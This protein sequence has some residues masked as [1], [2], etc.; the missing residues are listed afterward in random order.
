M[1]PSKQTSDLIY[2]SSEL[3]RARV[4]YEK[5]LQAYGAVRAAILDDYLA[6]WQM[7]PAAFTPASESIVGLIIMKRLLRHKL[8]TVRTRKLVESLTR[9]PDELFEAIVC[10]LRNG[11]MCCSIECA[12]GYEVQN[13]YQRLMYLATGRAY[14]K[15]TRCLHN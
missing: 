6:T 3:R 12:F 2:W 4:W 7:P 15:P 8:V 10:R 14:R 5:A 9:L 13:D 11:I 1:Q